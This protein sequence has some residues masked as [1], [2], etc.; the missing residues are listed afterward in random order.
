GEVLLVAGERQPGA[1]AAGGRGKVLGV[2]LFEGEGDLQS[3][4]GGGERG[5]QFLQLRRRRRGGEAAQRARDVGAEAGDGEPPRCRAHGE[6]SA[7][8]D[9]TWASI[10]SRT[11]R[12]SSGGRCLGSGIC[13]SIRRLARSD[14]QASP[15]PM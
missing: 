4:A 10:R 14:G 13:Q 11:L 12:N 2:E 9:L 1:Q 8:K 3:A 15:Q 6:S 5:V 7:I